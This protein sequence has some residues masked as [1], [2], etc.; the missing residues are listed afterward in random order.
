MWVTSFGGKGV[1]V[2]GFVSKFL[3]RTTFLTRVQ[4]EADDLTSRNCCGETRH[5]RSD[6]PDNRKDYG[7]CDNTGH[8]LHFSIISLKQQGEKYIPDHSNGMHWIGI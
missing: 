7:M 4:K 3:H 2:A 6:C 1:V 8:F 5:T